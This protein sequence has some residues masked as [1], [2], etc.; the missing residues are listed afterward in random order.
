MR[1]VSGQLPDC[2]P[3]VFPS[4]DPEP[5]SSL[6]P[7]VSTNTSSVHDVIDVVFVAN[8]DVDHDCRL[9]ITHIHTRIPCPNV[10]GMSDKNPL[11][12]RHR[13]RYRQIAAEERDAWPWKTEECL[14]P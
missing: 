8:T 12:S 6:A 14:E 1:K 2:L 3:Q 13:H 9:G 4:F 5:A 7:L 10:L 11:S